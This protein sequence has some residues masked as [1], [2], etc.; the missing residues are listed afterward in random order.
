M[1]G[2]LSI[3]VGV[4]ITAFSL[5]EKLTARVPVQGW[6]SLMIVLCLFSGVILFALAVLAEYLGVVV[7]M[8]MG[9]PLYLIVSRPCPRPGPLR[10]PRT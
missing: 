10:A 7:N 6:T 5:Y 3:V 1:L 8:A 4:G 2:C 9:R